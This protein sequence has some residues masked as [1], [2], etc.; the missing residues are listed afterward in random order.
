MTWRTGRCPCCYKKTEIVIGPLCNETAD[1]W[2]NLISR[3]R[4]AELARAGTCP[5]CGKETTIVAR[6]LI[7]R[8]EPTSKAYSREICL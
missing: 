1:G 2:D 8:F 5:W 3:S 4:V 6:T 7:G